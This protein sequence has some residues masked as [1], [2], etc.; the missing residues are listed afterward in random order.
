VISKFSPLLLHLAFDLL[1][2]TFDLVPVHDSSPFLEFYS[3]KRGDHSFTPS[4]T[5]VHR[6]FRIVYRFTSTSKRLSTRV[7]PATCF[8]L[9]SMAAFS[10]ELLTGPRNV[11]VPPEVMIFTLWAFMDNELSPP[12]AWRTFA[13]ICRSVSFSA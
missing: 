6:P 1:P 2:V 12:T 7:T 8:A 11:T 3:P 9:D 5:L 4:T 13:V 10:S